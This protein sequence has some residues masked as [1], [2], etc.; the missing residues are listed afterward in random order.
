MTVRS[1]S[2]P[3]TSVSV[4]R[5]SNLRMLTSPVVM[6]WPAVDTGDPGHRDEDPAAAEHL[7]DQ[8]QHARRL[9]V[10]AHG[11]DDIAHLAHLV[12][13]RV[14]DEETGEARDEHPGRSHTHGSEATVAGC[15]P[16]RLTRHRPMLRVM[17]ISTEPMLD[18]VVVDVFTDT[19]V[20]RQPA[21]RRLRG[22]RPVD[23]AAA[24][25]SRSSST[26]PRRR[27]R[28]R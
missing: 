10:A 2:S 16:G 21:G 14:V 18:Y 5:C 9:V 3:I 20:R 24:A 1:S 6:T 27:S 4:L 8:A 22:R 7:D 15:R 13:V 19:R 11:D 23:R 26:S 28:S 17:S 25:R 12:A